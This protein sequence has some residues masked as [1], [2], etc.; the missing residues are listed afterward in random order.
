MMRFPEVIAN[1]DNGVLG[2]TAEMTRAGGNTYFISMHEACVFFNC[3]AEM[4]DD[5]NSS[6]VVEEGNGCNV[7]CS[8]LGART[9][10]LKPD[11]ILRRS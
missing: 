11:D 8:P 6:M 4:I 2:C 10:N 5:C 1:E 7:L 3:N 9:R